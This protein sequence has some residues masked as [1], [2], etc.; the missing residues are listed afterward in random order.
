M[1]VHNSH[2]NVRTLVV[3]IKYVRVLCGLHIYITYI[4]SGCHDHPTLPLNC[5]E[6]ETAH[7]LNAQQEQKTFPYIPKDT[8]PHLSLALNE[9]LLNPKNTFWYEGKRS[10]NHRQDRRKHDQ[11][12]VRPPFRSS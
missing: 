2:S 6:D 4:T 11:H 1:N 3:M 5:G 10:P 12:V 8:L 7:A 9:P